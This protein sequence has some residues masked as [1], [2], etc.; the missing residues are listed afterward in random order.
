MTVNGAVQS[1][2]QGQAVLTPPAGQ[3]G[4]GTAGEG[5][6]AEGERFPRVLVMMCVS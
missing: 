1:A 4:S 3:V 6:E 2:R 5:G